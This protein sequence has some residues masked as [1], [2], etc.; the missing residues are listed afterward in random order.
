MAGRREEAVYV[1]QRLRGSENGRAAMLEIREIEAIVELERESGEN[2]TFFHMLFGIGK[3]DLHIARRVQLVI[4][5]QIL[6]IWTGIAGITMY[7]PTDIFPL[8]VRA[9]GNEWGV[10]GWSFGNVYVVRDFVIPAS[11]K[12]DNTW[13]IAELGPSLHFWLYRRRTLEEMDL[14]FAAKSPRV[15][16]AESNFTALMAEN[17]NLGAA[18]RRDGMVEVEKA[19]NADSEHEETVCKH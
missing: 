6:Q 12:D 18:H 2:I 8:K 19:L 11:L 15:W 9:N 5:L 4:W 17:P 16:T 1:L 7:A 13:Q 10:V 14:L 3:E